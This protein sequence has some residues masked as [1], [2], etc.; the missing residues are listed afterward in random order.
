MRYS[1]RAT[2]G[3]ILPGLIGLLTFYAVPFVW[4]FYLSLMSDTAKS[5]FIG[6]ENYTKIIQNP[7]FVLGL[8]NSLLLTAIGAPICWLIAYLIAVVLQRTKQKISFVTGT[9]IVPYIMPSSA[10]LLYFLL[11]FDWGGML[12][13]ILGILGIERVLWLSGSMLRVPVI[14]LYL[15]KNIGFCAIVFSAAMQAIPQSLYEYAD[16]EGISFVKRETKI[17]LPLIAPSSFLVMVFACINS[18]KIFR[19]AYYIGGPYPDE[20]IYTFQNYMNNMFQK[21]NY[22]NV[23]AGAYIFAAVV[24]AVFALLYLM[25]KRNASALG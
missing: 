23:M 1:K 9:L 15:W 17:T 7:M 22:S 5:V 18:F 13:R 21:L 25:Q 3:F 14:L 12:N 11:L 6:F 4:G 24:I 2:L 19:E 10:I 8:K 16:L 20:S